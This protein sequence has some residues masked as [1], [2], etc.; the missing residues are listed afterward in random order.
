[1]KNAVSILT[2]LLITFCKFNGLAYSHLS[3]YSYCAGNPTNCIDPTGEDVVVLNYTEGWH[4]AMLIQ[5]EKGKW[6]YYSVNGNNVYK[7]SNKGH[8]GGRT[9]NDV[10]V[11]SWNTPHDFFKSSYNVRTPNSKEDKSKNHFG[12]QE[13]YQ[14]KTTPE[15]DTTMR[16]TFTQIANTDYNLV[17][18]NCATVVQKTLIEAGL[19]VSDKPPVYHIFLDLIYLLP[20]LF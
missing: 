4:L 11:G 16:E 12:F 7:S 19:P 15:Q 5:N 14:I 8:S 18:N 3:T 2:A 1:M 10:A 13:G 9:F 17:S 6:Q 20:S